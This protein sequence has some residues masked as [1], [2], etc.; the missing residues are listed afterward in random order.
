MKL[1]IVI[2]VIVACIFML[3]CTDENFDHKTYLVP[4]AM[5]LHAAH[6]A[7]RSTMR[8]Q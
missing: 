7:V 1:P 6:S 4:L 3:G 2:A 5:S 8:N